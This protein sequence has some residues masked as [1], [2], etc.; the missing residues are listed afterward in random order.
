M[1]RIILSCGIVLFQILVQTAIGQDLTQTV[2]GTVTE[3]DSKLPLI[4]VQVIILDSDPL[5]GTT[6]NIN[7]DFR[8]ERVPI[9]RITLQ[10]TYIG[11]EPLIIPAL[12][13]S[14]GKELYL[15]LEMHGTVLKGT[16]V[17]VI[18][19]Q[20]KGESLNDMSLV[21]SRSISS[22][23]THR[24]AGG[25]N[26]PSRLLSNF[27]GV[28]N[29]QDGSTDIIVRGN[30]PKYVQWRLEGMPIT[31]PSHFAD[32]NATGI[33]G[34]STLNNNVLSSSDFMTG[35][36][37]PEYGNAL[38]GIYDLKLRTGNNER[39]ES[40]FGL[41]ILGTDLTFEGPFKSDYGGSFLINYRY[42]TI[43]L[44]D[45]MGLIPD[46][47]GIPKFQDA[48][49]KIVL[50]TRNYGR[51][52]IFGLAGL[53]KLD[54]EDVNPTVWQTPGDRGNRPDIREDFTKNA[55]LLNLGINNILSLSDKSHLI[56]T[57]SY[58]TEGVK[59]RV[60]E[61]NTTGNSDSIQSFDSRLMKSAYRANINYNR[62]ITNQHTIQSG[63]QYTL[64]DYDY[65][66]N[67][68]DA[69]G[70]QITP[71]D[72]QEQAAVI[73]NFV[74]WRYRINQD[75]SIVTG[76][77]NTNVLLNGKHTLEPRI[78]AR[79]Q[80]RPGT[81]LHAG[82]GN[83][84]TME[85]VHHYFTE[86][87]NE[88]GVLTQPN[89]DLG[90]LR[91]NHYVVGATHQFSRNLIGSVE[92]YYQDL[93]N[94]PV[95]NDESSIFATLNEGGD[96]NYVDLVNEGTGR[97]YGVEFTLERFFADSYYF[98]VN[99]SLF[100]SKYTALDGIERNTKFNANYL[101][102]ILAGKEFSGWG[103]KGNQIFGI[104]TKIFIGGGPKIIPMLRDNQGNLAVDPEN[105][106]FWD[107]GKAYEQSLD[108]LYSVTIFLS[109][110]WN[111]PQAAHELFLDLINVTNKQ[112]RLSEFYDEN[113]PS[114]VGFITQP[115]FFPNMMYRVYF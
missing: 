57:L 80:I 36:F 75:L 73:G 74:S 101:A 49:F 105:N 83:H 37:A 85:S 109:Y 62:R 12:V 27:A 7:G 48:V 104:N 102:N 71:I 40:V 50:P 26:D 14:S 19:S 28:N 18:G 20:Y 67:L 114:N 53:S 84:S 39:Y 52:S 107:F 63:S 3:T 88:A 46:I 82:Y 47:G 97:N 87:E 93:Y 66:L 54:F 34:L 99:A 4:G 106:I 51:F 31:N 8:L 91:A 11:Y 94:L 59:D 22:E 21:S 45:E 55:G 89:K 32:Q 5:R 1:N 35:A 15:Q 25:F 16:E 44:I 78:A 58:S 81:L 110:K 115:F 103:R 6:S 92:V 96:F 13:V 65:S 100:Q 69:D 41:G 30:S 29:S 24:F 17:T 56:T 113:E 23:E 43:S 72:F 10:V 33:G 60:Y 95:E 9:G 79:W 76:L 61:L 86:I 90:L 2:R 70:S 68:L 98:L 64:F 108:D 112:G 111:K 38:S 42:S 77:H